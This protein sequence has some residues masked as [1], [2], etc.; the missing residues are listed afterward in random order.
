MTRED[1]E[2]ALADAYL[3][4]ATRLRRDPSLHVERLSPWF[5]RVLFLT[6]MQH[7]RRN[8]RDETADWLIE[9]DGLLDL[10]VDAKSTDPELRATLDQVL[11]KL[12]IDARIVR[13]ASEG[14]TSSE[15]A[16]ALRPD[17]DLGEDISRAADAIRQRKSRAIAK[18]RKLLKETER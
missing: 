6:C 18:L 12:G 10:L 4:A 17:L 1:I 16:V 2:D 3:A 5:R 13:M 11:D 7:A 9:E 8:R 14:F 15:I